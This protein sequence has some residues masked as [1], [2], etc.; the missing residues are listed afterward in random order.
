VCQDSG[1]G[2]EIYGSHYVKD[3]LGA[4]ICPTLLSQACRY[5]DKAGHTVKF[6]EELKKNNREKEQRERQY[7]RDR[8]AKPVRAETVPVVQAFK[9]RFAALASDDED[10]V[11]VAPP[12][13]KKARINMEETP[14][15]KT[16]Q[17]KEEDFPSLTAKS[18][19]TIQ[20][21]VQTSYAAKLAA[22]PVPA[23]TQ[24]RYPENY[25]TDELSFD[26]LGVVFCTGFAHPM[27]SRIKPAAKPV[28]THVTK[29]TT[30]NWDDDESEDDEPTRIHVYNYAD[31]IDSDDD[32]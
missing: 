26:D 32:W 1:K 9:G 17:F 19:A 15:K 14:I 4:V 20:P 3:R 2:P 22:A 27:H 10:E 30:R 28:T 18:T 31:N 23:P 25:Q 21:Q 29:K 11:P 12:P 8:V 5:C 6:C 7:Q 16:V 13:T 24:I